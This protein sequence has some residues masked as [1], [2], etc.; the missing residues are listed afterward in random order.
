MTRNLAPAVLIAILLTRA[1]VASEPGRDQ[2]LLGADV[3][4]LPK[5]ES[6]GVVYKDAGKPGDV[7]E[8]LR[9]RGANC[10]RLRLFVNP[11]CK[12]SVVNDLPYTIALARRVKRAGMKIILAVH[13]SDVWADPG[14]QTLPSAWQ[15]LSFPKLV[16]KVQNY[17]AGVVTALAKAG[18]T[19]DVV[20]VGNEITNGMLWPYA[21][22]DD[23]AED[24]QK[25]NFDRLSELLKAGVRGVRSA[26]G[27][28]RIKIMLHLS[29]GADRGV[30]K[31]FF[32]HITARDVPFD[33]I[34]LS[35]YPFMG[36]KM[37][38]LHDNIIEAHE[39]YQKPVVVAET[40]F[41]WRNIEHPDPKE[42]LGENPQTPEGQK[43]FLRDLIS[44]VRTVSPR[45]GVIYWCPEFVLVKGSGIN[46]WWA[47]ELSLFDENA[48]A[49]PALDA[50]REEK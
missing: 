19:P 22:F 43:Q 11:S 2:F 47:G 44:M 31:W 35:F 42:Q 49:L 28:R 12:G 16:D 40:A 20:Q 17:T 29:R 10:I 9:V 8:M 21:R 45:G 33:L 6:A 4:L 32:D 30:P 50:F 41:P 5:L 15:S 26:E 23:H 7:I 37:Q 24:S 13:Y 3:S 1:A 34:G 48:N 27:N 36:D 14:D 18:A 46:G 39:L 38:N 25:V